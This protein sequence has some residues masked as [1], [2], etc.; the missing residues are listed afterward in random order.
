MILLPLPPLELLLLLLLA[1]LP[2]PNVTLIDVAPEE[3]VVEGSGIGTGEREVLGE[4]EADTKEAECAMMG[5]GGGSVRM[6]R[7]KGG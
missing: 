7:G 6:V 1:L 4:K 3:A 5:E 2:F